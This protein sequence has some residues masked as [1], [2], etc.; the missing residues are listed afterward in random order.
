MRGDIYDSARILHLG[1]VGVEGG[2]VKGDKGLRNLNKAHLRVAVS[3]SADMYGH[4]YFYGSENGDENSSA[5]RR[6]VLRQQ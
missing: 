1:A 4:I 6:I 5:G 3:G 2:V